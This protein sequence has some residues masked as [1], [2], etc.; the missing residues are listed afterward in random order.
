LFYTLSGKDK[1]QNSADFRDKFQI[2]INSDQPSSKYFLEWREKLNKEMSIFNGK[3]QIDKADGETNS[4][5]SGSTAIFT[6][7]QKATSNQAMV[8]Q[9]KAR[10]NNPMSRLA[11]FIPVK[12]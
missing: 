1:A 12:P 4:M 7:A 8:V 9:S 5:T 11:G 6:G 3:T 2:C 10:A